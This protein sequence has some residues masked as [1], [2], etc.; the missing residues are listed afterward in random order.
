[1][2]KRSQ[3]EG[4][5]HL[6]PACGTGGMLSVAEEYITRWNPQATL[7]LFGQE[8]NPES[9]AICRCDMLIK[10][11]VPGRINWNC[12]SKTGP[13]GAF[14]YFLANPPFGVEWK[15]V[16]EEI[17][18]E[19]P[20]LDRPAVRGRAPAR[21]RRVAPVLAAHDLQV[22]AGRRAPGWRSSSTVR[23]CLPAR[24]DR[25]RRRSA[26]GSSRTTG[27]K[28]SSL[29]PTSCSTTP[30]SRP[31]SGSSPTASRARRQGRPARRPRLL[32]EDAQDPGRQAER[33]QRPR[34]ARSP[35]LRRLTRR[36]SRPA[37]SR[38][39]QVKIFDDEF[40]YW[41]ITV[42]RPLRQRFEITEDTLAALESS[43]ALAKWDGR[44]AVHR[45]AA[46][47]ARLGVVDEAGRRAP[48]C[49]TAARSGGALW[50]TSSASAEGHLGGGLGL[51]PRRRGPEGQ[52]RHPCRTRTCAITRTCR[53]LKTLATTSPARS[54][55]Y[56]SDA[57]IDTE[58]KAKIGYEIPL[59]RYFYVYTPPAPAR[60][61]R[62]GTP[63]PGNP[64]PEAPRRG[65]G[66]TSAVRLKTA[67]RH[68]QC[69]ES[70]GRP[71]P[72]SSRL[73]EIESGTGSLTGAELPIKSALDS[74]LIP[75]R[76]RHV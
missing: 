12:F 74:I 66:M 49:S 61:D 13:T 40:G 35:T 70:D 18:D 7:A 6:D 73:E 47:S 22:E 68:A 44:D 32:G 51:R 27:S 45:R 38:A 42:D 5:P 54:P 2:G 34:S 9:Y 71:M 33:D 41:R 15:K 10:G 53:W 52:G 57:W 72:T 46:Q 30:A 19:H 8:V 17:E 60:R 1:M 11:E 48:A 16:Q 50:P 21:Q 56:V 65:D 43:K 67:G 25:A 36:S 23:R 4:H 76:R 29:C 63:R 37:A 55:P 3:R 31:T 14:D 26:A 24:Q 75:A 28:P 39:R 64:D 62:R 59:T 58:K 20:S 69:Q